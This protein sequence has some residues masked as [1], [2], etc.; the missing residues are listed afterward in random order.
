MEGQMDLFSFIGN[1][2]ENDIPGTDMISNNPPSLTNI[3]DKYE[4]GMNN[5]EETAKTEASPDKTPETDN[6]QEELDLE[7]GDIIWAVLDKKIE[8]HI[9]I[10]ARKK[11][12]ITQ[13]PDGTTR[14]LTIR[15]KGIV[16]EYTRDAAQK[17]FNQ[18]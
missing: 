6:N 12:C 15:S 17:L 1:I 16:W 18:K 7:E 14:R 3:T 8:S 4:Y 11:Y 10:K 9:I 2:E 5:K 13:A